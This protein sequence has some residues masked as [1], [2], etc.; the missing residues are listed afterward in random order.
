MG[1]FTSYA[2]LDDISDQLALPSLIFVILTPIFVITRCI[3]NKTRTGNLWLDDYLLLVACLIAVPGT[4]LMI[5]GSAW[6]FGKHEQDLLTYPAGSIPFD[7][8]EA[9]I[10]KTLKLFFIDQIIYGVVMGLFKC[11]V[12]V[13]Y[14]RIFET[15]NKKKFRMLC[16]TL[17]YAIAAFTVCSTIFTTFQCDPIKV[18][19][20]DAR[21]H[22]LNL[23]V[24][25]DA[26]AYFNLITYFL[27][28]FLPIPSVFGLP[29]WIDGV[30]MTTRRKVWICGLFGVG[31]L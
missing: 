29:P 10:E 22:C 11:A 15:P 5:V 7:S 27:V 30:Q 25:W 31:I 17:V 23:N 1:I 8:G 20:T 24:Y 26:R 13:W 14:T 3:S 6:G 2:P 4:V 9:L 12:L 21:A 16:W 18:A 28:T 19:W